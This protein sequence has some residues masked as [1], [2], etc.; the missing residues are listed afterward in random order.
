MDARIVL[1]MTAPARH[2]PPATLDVLLA[3]DHAAARG[4]QT[5]LDENDDATI[6]ALNAA[7]QNGWVLVHGTRRYSLSSEG[8]AQLRRASFRVVA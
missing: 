7:V 3:V 4:R 2:L 1:A 6:L 5:R 8:R